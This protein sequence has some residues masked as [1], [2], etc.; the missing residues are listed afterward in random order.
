MCLHPWPRSPVPG[1]PL[2]SALVP[3]FGPEMS[4]HL[5]QCEWWHKEGPEVLLAQ[6]G[7]DAGFPG[8]LSMGRT[9][10]ISRPA[11]FQTI[12]HLVPPSLAELIPP[13]GLHPHQLF[14]GRSLWAHRDLGAPDCDHPPAPQRAQHLIDVSRSCTHPPARAQHQRHPPCLSCQRHNTQG[15]THPAPLARAQHSHAPTLP[16]LL[17]G[18]LWDVLWGC[19]PRAGLRTPGSSLC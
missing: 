16:L 15:T 9:A 4:L 5:P 11:P 14:P 2:L 3:G 6:P 10:T 7:A 19:T 17:S 18:L 13:W 1:Q 12:P 8:L